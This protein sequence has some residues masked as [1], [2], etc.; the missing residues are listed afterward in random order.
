MDASKL[1]RP[2]IPPTRKPHAV[3]AG[4]RYVRNRRD[5]LIPLLMMALV[6]TLA[7]EFQVTI[8]LMAHSAFHLGATGFGLLYAAMGVGAVA[9]GL[10]LAGRVAGRVGTL[11]IAPAAFGVTLAAAAAAPGPV[12]AAVSLAFAGAASVVYSSTT[13]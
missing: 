1:Y 8:P 6:G 7:F 5:L 9:S 11:T 12:S 4:L 3:R 13:N 10:P 2:E